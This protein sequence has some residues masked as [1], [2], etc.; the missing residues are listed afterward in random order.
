[1]DS[2]CDNDDNDDNDGDV[3]GDKDAAYLVCLCPLV[4]VVVVGCSCFMLVSLPFVSPLLSFNKKDY[5][6][7]TKF[8]RPHNH[9]Q[10]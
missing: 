8:A 5:G 3:D 10:R 7:G 6:T 4:V 1:M 2:S 9:N